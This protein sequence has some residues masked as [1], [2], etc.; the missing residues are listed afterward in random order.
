MGVAVSLTQSFLIVLDVLCLGARQRIE[1][2]LHR[3]AEP[4]L[5]RVRNQGVTDPHQHHLLR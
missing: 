3:L 1:V 4:D 5:K 2:V